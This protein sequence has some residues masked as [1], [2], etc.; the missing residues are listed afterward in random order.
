MMNPSAEGGGSRIPTAEIRALGHPVRIGILALFTAD[1]K[2]SLAAIDLRAD[3]IERS[4]GS[5][6]RFSAA[7]IAYHRTRLQDADLLPRN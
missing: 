1:R 4:P 6:G 5:F 7:Q 3:L 2:R